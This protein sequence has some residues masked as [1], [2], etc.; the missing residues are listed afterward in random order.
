M[1]YTIKKPFNEIDADL[2]FN[3]LKNKICHEIISNSK[4][5]VLGVDKTDYVDYLTA[6][7]TI[8]E[9][10]IDFESEEVELYRENAKERVDERWGYEVYKYTE[11]V[12]C[13]KYKYVG[14]AEILRLHPS[15]N[16]RW[17]IGGSGDVSKID[18]FDHEVHIYF[19][20]YNQDKSEYNREKEGT[21]QK[22]FENLNNTMWY[23][24]NFNK[25]LHDM[26]EK[27]F[28]KIRTKYEQENNFF[29]ELNI[30]NNK[31]NNN[32]YTVPVI[33][34]KV[35]APSFEKTKTSIPTLEKATYEQIIH[36]IYNIYK[37]FERLP[38][39]YRGKDEEALR[40][41]VLPTLQTVF[42]SLS[43][44]VETFN[45]EGKTDI[46]IKEPGGGNVFVAECKIRK[47]EKLFLEAISQLMDRYVTWRDTKTALIVFVQSDG[48]TD[49][50]NK[51]K[52]AIKAHPYYV[53][54]NGSLGETSFS[55][56]F[57]LSNDKER[58]VYLELMMFHFVPKDK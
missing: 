45:K 12:F 43:S 29:R 34:K 46:C 38:N 19:S 11:Y 6:K 53:R 24:R 7:Y 49:I 31:K 58:I 47:G 42:G 26:A 13:V 27:E 15:N 35:I 33:Q 22:T 30:N 21:I 50:I 5:Y 39:N 51:A 48:F 28:D 14:S 8:E 37:S 18:V 36:T 17:S 40:D 55:Y 54:T 56:V 2:Y 1:Y 23:I 9:F 3:E 32:L 4:D 10:A 16:Y 52:S 25:N 41:G 44:S 20:I 57:H